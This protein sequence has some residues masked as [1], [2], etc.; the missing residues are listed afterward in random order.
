VSINKTELR[1]VRSWLKS[2]WLL[3]QQDILLWMGMAAIYLITAIIFSFVPLVG[4]LFV[5]LITPILFAG[6]LS[7]AE[8]FGHMI[9]H[10]MN[11]GKFKRPPL[12]YAKFTLRG[13]RQLPNILFKILKDPE[14]IFPM[15]FL[16]MFILAAVVGIKI[17]GL[18]VTGGSSATGFDI[19]NQGFMRGFQ[20]L[21]S[22]AILLAAYYL[23]TMFVFFA[24]HRVVLAKEMFLSAFM[25]SF[26][27][28]LKNIVPLTVLGLI[29]IV[30]L[31]LI[32]LI[33]MVSVPAAYLL[34]AATYLLAL[35]LFTASSYIS[36]RKIFR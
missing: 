9:K 10:K 18:I 31:I 22:G 23:L 36:Y 35:P 17:S 4:A 27:A 29:F 33:A 34:L 1:N 3:V 15:S 5:V 32:S 25:T 28:C 7:A 26:R 8:A 19:F 14:L 20:V 30:P 11:E 12:F 6:A 16:S 24:V 21:L 13:I 2:G